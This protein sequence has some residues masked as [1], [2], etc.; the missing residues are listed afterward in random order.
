MEAAARPAGVDPRE[1]IAAGRMTTLQLVIIAVLFC[2]NALD[3][4]DV[5]A[6]S[7]AAPGISR[8]WHMPPQSLGWVISLGLLATGC[9]SLLV[10]PLAD[11]VGRRPL[12]VASLLAMT[13]GMLICAVATRIETL[14]AGRLLTGLGVGALVP[15]ISALAAEYCNR[16]YRERGVIAMAVGFPVGGLVG[17]QLCAL[18]LRHFDWRAVFIAGGLITG[19][20]TL[21]PL[22]RV[23]ESVDYLV[24]RRPAGALGR[25]NA[26]LAR[27]DLPAVLS[28]PAASPVDRLSVLQ[29]LSRSGLLLS[30]LTI[31][32]AYALHGATFYY[33]LN[34]ITKILVDRS[35]SASQAA[36]VA[37]WCSGGGIA[38]ALAAA[39]LATRVR[40]EPLTVWTLLGA[41]LCLW[42]FAGTPADQT[43]CTAASML[44]GAFLYA[45]QVSL[46]ALMTRSFPV[47]VRATG[48][49][50][51][52]GIGRLGSIISPL[53]SGQLLELGLT[54]SRVSML[55][56]LGSLTGAVA[57]RGSLVL[58]R[59][60]TD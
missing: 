53:A 38:G 46:Y 17:G 44:L 29:I 4:F 8:E 27:L 23:P 37:S 57:L 60:L 15:C 34:W 1:L 25:V 54:Y 28:L 19:I 39:W 50:F 24:L 40:I 43:L 48:V 2:L 55:M 42:I 32:L 45:A 47:H 16:R 3:G 21:V 5:L 6:I 20:L 7:F 59:A 22:W 18:L 9:G 36:S 12:I 58:R 41:A 14:S 10:A 31:T 51:V 30:V 49:G 35:L 26:I 56:A 11:R 52:T 33:A 13:A